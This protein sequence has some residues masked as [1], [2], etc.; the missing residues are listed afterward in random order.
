MLGTLVG[1]LCKASRLA[2]H[3]LFAADSFSFSGLFRS[4]GN[5][6]VE[7]APAPPCS[8]AAGLSMSFS[9]AHFYKHFCVCLTLTGSSTET[10]K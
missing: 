2:S 3:F 4:L 1:S 5:A 9:Q 8:R 7:F 10:H 6:W